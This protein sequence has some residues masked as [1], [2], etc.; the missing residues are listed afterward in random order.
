[1]ETIAIFHATMR[2]VATEAGVDQK[3]VGYFFGSK[4]RL[5]VAATELPIRPAETLPAILSGGAATVGE[6]M[7]RFALSI[8]EDS[9]AGCRMIGLVRASAA[10][11]QAA[12]M[13]RDLVAREILQPAVDLLPAD[14]PALRVNLLSSQLIGLVMVRYVIRAEPL[15][16]LA[17]EVVAA[18]IA[19][20][21]QRYLVGAL[22]DSAAE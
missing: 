12:E 11:P 9:N 1:M 4:Q 21:L 8:L 16:S 20:T 13:F 18:S 15:A 5:F 3:L 14:R 10:E 7:A 22:E 19:P 2:S 6:R 17:P